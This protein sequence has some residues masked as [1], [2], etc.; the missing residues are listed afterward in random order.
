MT[1]PITMLC[2]GAFIALYFSHKP[3]RTGVHDLFSKV[4]DAFK[5]SPEALPPVPEVVTKQTYVTPFPPVPPPVNF[6]TI[7]VVQAPTVPPNVVSQ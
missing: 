3:F 1:E 4:K 7:Q 2:I 6:P 5:G